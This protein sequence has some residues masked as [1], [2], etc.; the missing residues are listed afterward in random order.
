[1]LHGNGAV[2]FEFWGIRVT[3]SYLG[4]REAWVFSSVVILPCENCRVPVAVSVG[5]F[6]AVKNVV[7]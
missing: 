2:A 7:L 5:C 4:L 3:K 1:M 6:Q